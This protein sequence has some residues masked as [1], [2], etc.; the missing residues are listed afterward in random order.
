LS[1][2]ISLLSGVVASHVPVQERL[3]GWWCRSFLF[4]NH[5]YVS[6][7]VGLTEGWRM[8]NSR[9]GGVPSFWAPALPGMVAQWWGW[10]HRAASD[11]GMRSAGLMSRHR[12]ERAR[13][14]RSYPFRGFHRP[15][16]RG[17][18]WRQYGSGRH[19]VMEL[20]PAF[21]HSSR[22]VPGMAAQGGLVEQRRD[23]IP[24]RCQRAGVAGI[25]L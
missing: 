12:P 22:T 8:H 11:G 24:R 3:R 5:P 21:P 9:R 18:A 1:W 6:S 15:L 7:R 19:N 10:P 20:T 4:G 14:R 16:S 2:R 13:D 25:R 17:V 23:M